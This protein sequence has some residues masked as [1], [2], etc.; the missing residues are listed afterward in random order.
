MRQLKQKGNVVK[1][2]LLAA[3]AAL[4]LSLSMQAHA[5]LIAHADVD[6]LATFKDTDTGLVWLKL[7]NLFGQSYAQQV[8]TANAAGFTVADIAA[9]ETLTQGSARLDSTNWSSVAE[10]IGGSHE[11]PVMWG[12]YSNPTSGW[13]YGWYYSYQQN[14]I[15]QIENLDVIDVS[16]DLGLWAYRADVAPVPEPAPLALLGAGL[17]GVV[18]GHGRRARAAQ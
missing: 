11:R 15:W 10:I 12:N 5:A 1:K 14:G 6:G 18:I 8:A 16:A 17:L 7:N 4:A 2:L 13:Q 3:G 9:L